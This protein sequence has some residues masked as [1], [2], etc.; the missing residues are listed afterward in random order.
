MNE[1]QWTPASRYSLGA[2]LIAALLFEMFW[3]SV[4]EAIEKGRLMER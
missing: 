2:P 1:P 3:K 4:E